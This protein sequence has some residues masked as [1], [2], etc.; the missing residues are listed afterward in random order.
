MAS[1][2][3]DEDPLLSLDD[4]LGSVASNDEWAYRQAERLVATL[5]GRTGGPDRR[6]EGEV[7][8]QPTLMV[9]HRLLTHGAM[10]SLDFPVSTGKEANVFRGTS[11]GGA[12]VAVK[13]YRTNTA[14]FK[15][16]QQYIEGDERFEGRT[17]DR[18]GLVAAWCQKEFRNLARMREA[19]VAVPEPRKAIAN[20][21]VMEYLGTAQ[22]PWPRMKEMTPLADAARLYRAVADDY[23]R[24]YNVADLVHADLSEYNVL[25]EGT[26]G[27]ATGW[28]P[29]MIDVGQAVLKSHPRARE[30]LLRDV[31]N[32]TAFFRRQGVEAASEDIVARLDHQR[33]QERERPVKVRP[34]REEDE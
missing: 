2:T 25:L 10:K 31:R 8:D 14:T 23:V 1:E 5:P 19:G 26:D 4:E 9:L 32:L 15:H 22:G 24:A 18:R 20:V 29:R 34:G 7:F 27:P 16:V 33:R 21:L 30:F 13:I 28:T 11:P 12:F 3:E 6:T 17:G